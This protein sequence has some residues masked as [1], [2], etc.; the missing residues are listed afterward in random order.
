[1]SN[2]KFIREFLKRKYPVGTEI[3][4]STR[5][6][7]P[8]IIKKYTVF[9][10]HPWT[11]D[12]Y[13]PDCLP[14]SP[15]DYCIDFIVRN[16]GSEA[17]YHLEDSSINEIKRFH[18]LMDERE[19]RMAQLEVER[20]NKEALDN[21]EK[22]KLEIEKKKKFNNFVSKIYQGAQGGTIGKDIFGMEIE[23]FM[24]EYEK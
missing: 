7:G 22:E 24:K 12:D 9:E 17:T 23:K 18:K 14:D 16:P 20:A 8:Y 3:Y 6:G 19:E 15:D 4:D 2:K 1:M 10:I 11:K 21:I 13:N 5:S